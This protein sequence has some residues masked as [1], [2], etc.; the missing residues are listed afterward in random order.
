MPFDITSIFTAL[1]GLFKLGDD[2]SP[3]IEQWIITTI[4]AEKQRVMT[5]RLRRCKR[6]CRINRLPTDL[7]REEVGLMFD[8]LSMAQQA[9]IADLM[10]YEVL[11]HDK[12]G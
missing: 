5:R 12:K 1:S 9:D 11:N 4:P 6:Y 8:D 2:L 10:V 7:I 3:A